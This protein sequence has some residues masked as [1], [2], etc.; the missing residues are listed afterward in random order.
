MNKPLQYKTEARIAMLGG[1]QI[2]VEDLTPILSPEE[3]AERRREIEQRLY[4]VF[5]KYRDKIVSQG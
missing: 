1:K 4:D 5:V 2:R 3:Q